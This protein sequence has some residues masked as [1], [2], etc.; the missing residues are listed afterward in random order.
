M[1]TNKIMVALKV[2]HSKSSYFVLKIIA[3]LK[4]PPTNGFE[5]TLTIHKKC[6]EKNTYGKYASGKKRNGNVVIETIYV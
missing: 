4:M 6:N 2:S 1:A 5:F 3:D